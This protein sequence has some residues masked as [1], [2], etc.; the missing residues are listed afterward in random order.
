MTTKLL[1]SIVSIDEEKCDGCGACVIACAE[2]ALQIID[3]KEKRTDDSYFSDPSSDYGQNS[4]KYRVSAEIYNGD[5]EWLEAHHWNVTVIDNIGDITVDVRNVSDN[6]LLVSEMNAVLLHRQ[7]DGIEVPGTRKQPP[8]INPMTFND[9]DFGTYQ[10][11]VYCWDMLTER[12]P[13]THNSTPTSITLQQKTQ[14]RLLKVTVYY[15]GGTV[16][17]ADANVYLDSH[18][19]EIA[20]EGIDDPWTQRASEVSDTDG[21]VT[22]QA[23]PANGSIEEKYLIRVK[24]AN[25]ALVGSR[26]NVTLRNIASGDRYEIVTSEPKPATIIEFN[27]PTGILHRGQQMQAT[28]TIKNTGTTSR[29]FWVGLSFSEPSAGEWPNG[30][31]D[32]PPIQTNML[33]PGA[34][35]TVTFSMDILWWL[36]PGAYTAVTAVWENYDSQNNIMV[37]PRY[38]E[39]TLASFFLDS[40]EASDIKNYRVFAPQKINSLTSPTQYIQHLDG[41]RSWMSSND[42]EGSRIIV[43]KLTSDGVQTQRL[44]ITIDRSASE[45]IEYYFGKGSSQVFL[46][47]PNNAILSN[48][49]T[50]IDGVN[51]VQWG[52][53]TALKL[54]F[55]VTAPPESL[56]DL[57]V[58]KV[59]DEAIESGFTWATSFTQVPPSYEALPSSEFTVLAIDFDEEKWGRDYMEFNTFDITFDLSFTDGN[60]SDISF[61]ADLRYALKM[62]ACPKTFF[63]TQIFVLPSWKLRLQECR[64]WLTISEEALGIPSFQLEG[65]IAYHTYSGYLTDP[66]D[67]TDGNVFVYNIDTK[68]NSNITSVMSYLQCR[69]I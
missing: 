49:V 17:Y 66:K 13:F 35:Q 63:G 68:N 9:I 29:S 60:P 44:K 39:S 18:N 69:I 58:G 38:D 15:E 28:V 41:F 24:N 3:G 26:D 31:Y 50:H 8:S 57:I 52:G 36:A 20:R 4:G 55:L 21:I 61:I 34:E 53:L 25:G 14:K 6:R 47:L 5:R 65:R 1:R 40:Y 10:V 11:D 67:L 51:E 56:K 46:V 32:I 62:T 64:R 23:W 12:Y 2:G 43:E 33:S 42:I 7:S 22:F 27:P 30:W 19:G 59:V 48:V 54:K 37:A 45:K 16:L